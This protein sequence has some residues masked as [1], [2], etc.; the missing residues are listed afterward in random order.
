MLNSSVVFPLRK[1]GFS[2]LMLLTASAYSQLNP[3]LTKEIDNAL[4]ARCLDSSKTAASVVEI[5]TGKVVY[6]RNVNQP[7]MPASILKIVT[8]AAALNYLGPEYRFTTQFLHTGRRV[9]DVIQGDLVVRGGGDP[10]LSSEQLWL[11]ATRIK[12]SGISEV[13]G[14]LVIDT[15]FFDNYDRAPAWDEEEVSQRA[16]N[17]KLSAFS[18]NFNTIS[19]HVLPGAS[20][21]TPLNVWLEPT[22]LY[23]RINNL[24]KTLRGGKYTVSVRRGEDQGS[25]VEIQVRGNLPVG[26]KESV[27]YLNV[28]NPTRYAAEAFR[29]FLQQVG[30]K[31][32]GV[33]QVVST[34]V[35][36]KELYSYTSPP[37]SLILKD[38]NTYSNNFMAE[39]ILKTIAADRYGVPGSHAEGLKMIS[40][41]LH[42]RGISTDGVVLADGSGLSRKNRFTAKAMTDLL[43]A[44]YLRFD[45]GPD[46]LASLRVMGAYGV[47]SDRLSNSPAHGQIRAKTGTLSGVSALAGYVATP[48]GK[49]FAYALFENQNRCG[50][51]GEKGIEDRIVTA[52]HSYGGKEFNNVVQK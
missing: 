30:V 14:K 28:D 12:A 16:Y 47:L 22:P 48:N 5:P 15:H 25:E 46:F 51:G 49:L 8:T 6:T 1:V 17:A 42:L 35:E 34:P 36:G 26:A 23:M 43:T 32:N 31:I 19:V 38:L 21:G 50:H 3:S 18:I 33:T 24:G 52:I 9:G 10:K 29:A 20:V 7:L 40:D 39:Q 13:T 44:M 41:F 2:L 11:I 37:L 27:I 4:T 45:T